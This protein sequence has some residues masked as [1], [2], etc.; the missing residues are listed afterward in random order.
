MKKK[1]LLTL[2]FCLIMSTGAN[3]LAAQD[4]VKGSVIAIHSYIYELQPGVTMDQ[5]MDFITNK[6]IP[7]FCKNFPGTKMYA[8][9]ADRGVNKFQFGMMTVFESVAARDNYYPAEDVASEAGLAADKKM[10]PVNMEFM[11]YVKGGT[12]TS[13][14]DWIVR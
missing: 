1:A 4:P 5:F 10:E 12:R 8:L 9:R 2:V 14:T 13:Y 3:Q 11:K 6:Y 7:E